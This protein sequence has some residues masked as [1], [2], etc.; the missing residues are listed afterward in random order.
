MLLTHQ[1]PYPPR[2]FR[3]A[4]SPDPSGATPNSRLVYPPTFKI[5]PPQSLSPFPA[6]HP[7]N[8]P[9][10]PVFA[11]LPNSSI[12]RRMLVL[13]EQREPKDLSSLSPAFATDPKIASITR[14][15]ATLPNSLDL[16]SFV[17]HTSE[18]Q[19]VWGVLC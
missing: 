14:L 6:T 18:K 5:Y 2:D 9:V 11:I 10:T 8:P 15:F 4:V 17:C 7:K 19:G 16:K 12:R 13:S 1:H 3:F